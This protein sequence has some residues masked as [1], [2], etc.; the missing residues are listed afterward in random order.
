MDFRVNALLD[1]PPHSLATNKAVLVGSC[2]T[3][4]ILYTLSNIYYTISMK[5]ALSR[6]T[7]SDDDD[8]VTSKR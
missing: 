8:D 6:R 1:V 5:F 3:C 7:L 2:G 4:K